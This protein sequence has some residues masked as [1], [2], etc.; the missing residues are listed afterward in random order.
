MSH[1]PYITRVHE[2]IYE[3]PAERV[4]RRDVITIPPTATI[5]ELKE[6]LR[7]NRISGVPVVEEGRMVGIISIE[8]LIRALEQGDTRA[9]VGDK[10][11]RN[12]ITVRASDSVIEAVKRFATHKV[13]RLPVVDADGNLVGIITAGDISRGL[14]EAVG[15][16]YQQ[17]E[18]SPGR[19]T[20]FFDD[21]TSDH[22]E[23][24]LRYHVKA[25]DF[26]GGGGASSKLK[27]VLSYLGTPAQVVRRV[28]IAAYEAEMNLVIHTNEGG[29]LV[30]VIQPELIRVTAIDNGPGIEDVEA[31]MRPG[32]STA[33]N[34]I[35]E[36]GFGAGMGLMNVKRCADRMNLESRVGVGTK[37][38][39]EF[40]LPR[41]KR[42]RAA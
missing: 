5:G 38:E 40:D 36:L 41:R 23:L 8:N 15:L 42:A 33:P 39:T 26:R 27:R 37:L 20:H 19:D 7:L 4:M 17:E 6:V 1:I 9:L 35:R 32:Y 24:I 2:L 21:V 25:N 28:A 29:D 14:L 12:V 34:W 30:A 10:M 18:P 22:T 3:L 11:T 13:G 31:V 16:N